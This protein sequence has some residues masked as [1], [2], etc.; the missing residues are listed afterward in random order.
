MEVTKTPGIKRIK[1]DKIIRWVGIPQPYAEYH[2]ILSHYYFQGY[3]V[4]DPFSTWIICK[5]NPIVF[6]TEMGIR[7]VALL[8]VNNPSDLNV[9]FELISIV[10][11]L[12]LPASQLRPVTEICSGENGCSLLF[13]CFILFCTLP[14]IM[15][16][17]LLHIPPHLD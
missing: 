2:L 9:Y 4:K 14:L 1:C 3:I 15:L 6:Q 10:K 13:S 17:M 16:I 7:T 8:C 11:F 5:A 12:P